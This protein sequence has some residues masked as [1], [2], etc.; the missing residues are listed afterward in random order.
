MQGLANV[1]HS[2]HDR[3]S[4]HRKTIRSM[5]HDASIADYVTKL[6]TFVPSRRRSGDEEYEASHSGRL[7]DGGFRVERDLVMQLRGA[8]AGAIPAE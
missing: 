5:T 8:L 1:A 6:K 2:F 3:D 4:P 7:Y